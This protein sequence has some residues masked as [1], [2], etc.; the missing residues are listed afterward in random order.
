[1]EV[2]EVIQAFI[3][4][5]KDE[6]LLAKRGPGVK[7]YPNLW[8]AP[9][10]HL[11]KGETLVDCLRRE[12]KEELGAEVVEIVQEFPIQ[13]LEVDGRL[14]KAKFYI[15]RVGEV[16]I[17]G[18]EVV[19]YVWV[20]PERVKDYPTTPKLSYVLRQVGLLK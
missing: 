6:L 11:E 17:D 3:I 16:S 8:S 2:H 13:N 20:L 15:V 14:W 19:E 18:V 9:A 5:D 4:N 7:V 1:M 12:V 10:G